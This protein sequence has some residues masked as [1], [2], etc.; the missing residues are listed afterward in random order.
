MARF[1][2]DLVSSKVDLRAYP[3]AEQWDDWTE[4]ESKDWPR[5]VEKHYMLIPTVCFNCEAG[6]GLLSYVDKESLQIRKF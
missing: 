3:P 2:I 5:R 1:A 4:Y 6:C